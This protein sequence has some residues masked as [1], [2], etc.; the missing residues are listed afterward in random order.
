MQR[1][2][3]R[4]QQQK[5]ILLNPPNKRAFHTPKTVEVNKQDSK[6]FNDVCAHH[7]PKQWGVGGL[8]ADRRTNSNPVSIQIRPM[9]SVCVFSLRYFMSATPDEPV[10]TSTW[11]KVERSQRVIMRS[12]TVL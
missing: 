6:P 3:E 12:I 4:T 5:E 9:S 10:F 8:H 7:Q 11:N 1:K 2:S